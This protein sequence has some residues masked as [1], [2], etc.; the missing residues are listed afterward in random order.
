MSSQGPRFQ[1]GERT[2]LSMLEFAL[3][4]LPGTSEGVYYT[5]D[6]DGRPIIS[7]PP[8]AGPRAKPMRNALK[9]KGATKYLKCG[10]CRHFL[11][12]D[13]RSCCSRCKRVRYCSQRC[14]IVHW[15]NGHR[16]ECRAPSPIVKKMRFPVI[17]RNSN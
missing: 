12:H 17:L 2:D 1:T 5:K 15:K 16:E 3:G 14:Q 10:G 13:Q 4:L 7:I 8:T 11:Q 6:P 9:K